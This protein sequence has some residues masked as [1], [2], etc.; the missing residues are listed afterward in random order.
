LGRSANCS[1]S[2]L[3]TVGIR[4]TK[5]SHSIKHSMFCTKRFINMMNATINK[6]HLTV[7]MG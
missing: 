7:F 2:N 1:Q 4:Y 3:P 6:D 5:C